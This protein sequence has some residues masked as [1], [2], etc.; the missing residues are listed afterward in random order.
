MS[1]QRARDY[2]KAP[3]RRSRACLK[4]SL[5]KRPPPLGPQAARLQIRD[6]RYRETC[7]RAA[8]G[9]SKER[10]HYS[11]APRRRSPAR[12]KRNLFSAP[13]PTGT[14]GGS[15]ADPRLTLLGGLQASRLRSQQRARPLLQSA[16]P[17]A[18][19]PKTQPALSALL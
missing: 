8:C 2:S 12:L 11:K 17:I 7:R 6:S 5:L 18:N 14:A 15:P 10:A 1:Q 16:P 13:S 3:R 4:R 9:P 19:L